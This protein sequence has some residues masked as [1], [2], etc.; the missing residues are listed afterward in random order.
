MGDSILGIPCLR[1]DQGHGAGMTLVKCAGSA[2]LAA[3]PPWMRAQGHRS[4]ACTT[5]CVVFIGQ[6]GA[7]STLEGVVGFRRRRE[8]GYVELPPA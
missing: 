1:L 6:G 3:P 4:M 2:F 5:D 8:M 7:L